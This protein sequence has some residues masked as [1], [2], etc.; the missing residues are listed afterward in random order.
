[1]QVFD[2]LN[3]ETQLS[4]RFL[5]E[6]SA[7]TGK[8]F[9]IEQIALRL[10][11]EKENPLLLEEIL[12]V[13]F[14]RSAASDLK[15]RIL[16]N[17][18]KILQLL[19]ENSQESFPDYLFPLIA[20]GKKKEILHSLQEALLFFDSAQVF[21]IHGFCLRMLQEF[22]FE[23]KQGLLSSFQENVKEES[24]FQEAFFDLL[25]YEEKE[26][27]PA[28]MAILLK[29]FQEP[30]VLLRRLMNS[31]LEG[32]LGPKELQRIMQ[33]A[34]N[35]SP[36]RGEEVFASFEKMYPFFKISSFN[37]EELFLEA[38]LLS[39][40]GQKKEIS[41]SDVEE[42]LKTSCKLFSFLHPTNKKLKGPS[43]E[44]LFSEEPSLWY[45]Q[46][47]LYPYLKKAIS[48][49]HLSALLQ[50]LLQEKIEKK[51]EKEDLFTFD[52]ILKK[53]KKALDHK[54]FVEAVRNKYR[55][56]MIDEFQD[57]D[58]VQWEIFRRLFLEGN[59]LHSFFL[60]GDPKQSIYR[61]R[62]ADLYTYYQAANFL[63]KESCFFLDT[64]YRS[65][66]QLVR[67][68]NAL[69]SP[70]TASFWLFLPELKKE[71]PYHP[72]KAG[73]SQGD[74]WQDGKKPLHFFIASPSGNKNIF[75]EA[76]ELFFS[77]LS[78][79]IFQLHSLQQIP[80]EEMAILVKDRFQQEKLKEY[81]LKKRIPFVSNH[82][83][84]LS[85]SDA[86]WAL[87]EF[88]QA[89]FSPYDSSLLKRALVG[90]YMGWSFQEIASDF[91]QQ[92]QG[93]I[94]QLFFLRDLLEKE[95]LSHF[96]REFFSSIWKRDQKS[97][98]ERLVS[99]RDL[100]L[101]RDTLTFNSLLLDHE[102]KKGLSFFSIDSFFETIR[103]NESDRET[104]TVSS[105]EG[106]QIMT[107]HAS[108]GLEF[109]IVFAL[110]LASTSPFFDDEGLGLEEDAEKMRQFYVALTRA[111]KRSYIPFIGGEEREIERGRA[112]ASDL[113]CAHVLKAHSSEKI[114]LSSFLPTLDR[115]KE[116]GHLSYERIN[117]I[118]FL[119]PLKTESVDLFRP[120]RI[121]FS[122]SSS[123]IFSFSSLTPFEIEKKEELFSDANY[124]FSPH[125][126]PQGRE[127]GICLHRIFERFFSEEPSKSLKEILEEELWGNSFYDH[128][129]KIQEMVHCALTT[130][131]Q[132]TDFPFCL[133][134]VS[135]RE[136]MA[137][138][139]FLFSLPSSQDLMKGSV[140]LLFVHREKYY[141]VDWK[142]SWLGDSQEFYQNDSLFQVMKNH[143]YFLQASIYR[144]AVERYMEKRSEELSFGGAFY[145]FLR[146]LS[147][148]KK[149]NQGVYAFVPEKKKLEIAI[150]PHTLLA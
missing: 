55:A 21:T 88:F 122:K 128:R 76:Q 102:K 140:D 77:Y 78:Q 56:V 58:P 139:E 35:S 81:F 68:L 37:K 20:Q 103:K 130:P 83:M 45:F 41:L 96:F 36:I 4:G 51:L 84:S 143:Q 134:E 79:E 74:E 32:S 113:F 104:E 12:M 67:A 148:E 73:L 30:K 50:K 3:K 137:E 71:L 120:E 147:Q 57:T 44:G 19:K 150:C 42:F 39:M 129:E 97:V 90:P 9:A 62:K 48:P 135:R 31:R 118:L 52:W 119:D 117:E 40:M 124:C 16:S 126:L 121:S 132:M 27:A 95:G 54:E 13:T 33:E 24:L 72:V 131:L 34:I 22:A 107:L 125:L 94:F 146:G 5:L 136:R 47:T 99:Q 6:A 141:F 106:V 53:M 1:M 49:A 100:S 17:I 15:K 108:K 87:K 46:E 133:E 91:E 38:R 43:F 93:L 149:T 18:K 89:L 7:G 115:L 29:K 116:E 110:G 63:G 80:Y 70:A 138:M 111:K 82:S 25:H 23:A 127:M 142:S 66:P 8:T 11:I 65:S 10:L 98:L 109:T 112:S 75:K 14:T 114:S 59:S 105:K 144:E 64:N 85:E 92:L 101:Y 86:L 28:Q 61:F 123:H 145:V 26:I 2:C 60:V 69:F